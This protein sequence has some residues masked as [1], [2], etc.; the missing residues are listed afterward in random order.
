MAGS[1]RRAAVVPR[2]LNAGM[3]WLYRRLRG[4][5]VKRS[6]LLL[7]THGRR[8]GRWR[9]IP[10]LYVRESEAYVVIGSN[11][12]RPVMPAWY[13][14]L[15]VEPSVV[16]EVG[17]HRFSAR[18]ETVDGDDRARLWAALVRLYHPYEAYRKRTDRVFPIVRLTPV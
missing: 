17:A 13:L 14:N 10:L 4:G 5:P 3:I 12:G 7:K 8:S 15:A 16:V 2:P 11:G 1:P 18:A 6:V 9:T